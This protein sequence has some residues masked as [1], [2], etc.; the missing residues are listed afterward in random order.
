MQGIDII[1]PSLHKSIYADVVVMPDVE[2][3]ESKVRWPIRASYYI[4]GIK[5]PWYALS[6]AILAPNKRFRTLN[7]GID[8]GP[9]VL[10]LSAVAD[11]VLLWI[12]KLR[13][14]D[15]LHEISWLRSWIP[16][17]FVRIYIGGGEFSEKVIRMVESDKYEVKVI[18]ENGTTSMPSTW[19]ITGTIKDRDIQASITIALIGASTSFF[20][21]SPS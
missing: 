17:S 4:D 5:D 21:G 11:N 18:D 7:V 14:K 6:L 8:P 20:K 9:E 3:P 16:S 1:L 2:S 19:S 15:I 12:S 10:G 13:L